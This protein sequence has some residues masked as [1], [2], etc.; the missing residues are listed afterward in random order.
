[1]SVN[2]CSTDCACGFWSFHHE[3]SIPVGASSLMTLDYYLDLIGD[4]RDRSNSGHNYG[5]GYR[6]DLQ[7]EVAFWYDPS[8]GFANFDAGPGYERRVMW[9]YESIPEADRYRWRKLECP[10]CNRIYAGWY[11]LQPH[12]GIRSDYELYDT[13]Y[14]HA[15][16]DEPCR[17]DDERLREWTVAEVRR[18]VFYWKI[19]Y[20]SK[21]ATL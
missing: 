17:K 10:F 20:K 3:G 8:G 14:F 11:R 1:M 9:E 5:Y 6:D 13:S 4:T 19:T 18:M 21:K 7:G 12:G 16:S 2:R 15:F